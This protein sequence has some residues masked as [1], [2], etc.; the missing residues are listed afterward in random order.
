MAHVF[1]PNYKFKNFMYNKIEQKVPDNIRY[2]SEWKDYR[3][4]DGHCIVDKEICGCGYTEYCIRLDNPYDT[5]LCSPRIVLLENKMEKHQGEPNI[6]YF[7]NE[8]LKKVY[9]ETVDRKDKDLTA[10]NKKYMS[11]LA[12]VVRN[13]VLMCRSSGLPIRILCTYDSFHTIYNILQE[14]IQQF[15]II[16]DEFSSIFVDSFFKANVESEFLSTLSKKDPFTGNYL[17]PNVIYL[18][19]TPMM[20]KYL[21]R[22]PEFRDLPYYHMLWPESKVTKA[23]VYEKWVNNVYKEI[24]DLIHIYKNKPLYRPWKEVNGAPVY[25]E[26]IVFFVNSVSM[27]C[28]II[29]KAKLDPSE[30]NIICARTE[31]NIKALKKIKHQIG[32]IPL[33]GEPNKMFT[34]C[35]RTTYLGSDFYSTNAMTVIAS[36]ANIDSMIVDV[37]LDLP[38]I[39]GRQ[40]LEVNPWKNECYVFYSTTNQG[41]IEYTW[42]DLKEREALKLKFSNKF[43][44][45]FYE[46]QSNKEKEYVLDMLFPHRFTE[47]NTNLDIGTWKCYLGINHHGV[48]VINDL[49]VIAEERSWEL[50]QKEYINNITVIKSIA[51]NRNIDVSNLQTVND[52]RVQMV[53][54]QIKS[55]PRLDYKFRTYCEVREKFKD[56]QSFTEKLLVYYTKS[57]FE[58]LYSHFGYNKCRSVSFQLSDLRKIIHDETNADPLKKKILSTFKVG[59]KYLLSEAKETL[60]TIYQEVGLLNKNPKASDL[61]DYFNTK[62]IRKINNSTGKWSKA[63]QLISIK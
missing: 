10:H 46:S 50:T 8:G 23:M 51:D 54:D 9:Q 55:I 7:S 36:D 53:I 35:T 14:L 17:I 20:D 4:P 22:L 60:R 33:E 12:G 21:E 1:K 31:K 39:L 57:E 13:H 52:E 18:S 62:M 32:R 19:A 45:M 30:C 37:R 56:D 15:H 49:L 3:L 5:I 48:P 34:F 2:L 47:G 24:L 43:I 44:D 40:R 29:K 41:K 28:K 59:D 27:I 6:F 38:Q 58:N 42:E 25:S 16:V 11:Y 61:E 63:Y 26:E